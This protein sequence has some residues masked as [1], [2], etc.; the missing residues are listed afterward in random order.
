MVL[1]LFTNG[2]RAMPRSLS[3]VWVLSDGAKD[4]VDG[5]HVFQV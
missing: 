3:C 2:I 5:E 1:Q 4:A